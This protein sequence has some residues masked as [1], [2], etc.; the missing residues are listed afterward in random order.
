MLGT[1]T[2]HM[3]GTRPLAKRDSYRLINDPAIIARILADE[4]VTHAEV[5]RRRPKSCIQ[6][7]TE[8]VA[9]DMAARGNLCRRPIGHSG[10][11]LRYEEARG[12][13]EAWLN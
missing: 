9:G 8:V 4:G 11:H 3:K 2:P 6:V 13:L 10:P 7:G 1:P 5:E 12:V